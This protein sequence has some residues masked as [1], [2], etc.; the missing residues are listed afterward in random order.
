E[1][2]GLSKGG[3]SQRNITKILDIPKSTVSEIIKKYNKVSLTTTASRSGRPKVL[4]E[5]DSKNFVKIDKENKSNTLEEITENFN[6]LMA[7]SVS[8][9]IVQRILHKEGY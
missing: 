9:R 2:V 6:I 4:S 1:I 7:I 5:C 8:T 3:F